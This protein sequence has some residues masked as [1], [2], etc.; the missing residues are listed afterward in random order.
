MFFL[1]VDGGADPLSAPV[2]SGVVDRAGSDLCFR[3]L[4]VISL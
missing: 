4:G 3:S 2:V 1:R